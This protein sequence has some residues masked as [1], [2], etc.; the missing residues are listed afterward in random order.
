MSDDAALLGDIQVHNVTLHSF[1]VTVDYKQGIDISGQNELG[2]L[3][4]VFFLQYGQL[5][6]ERCYERSAYLID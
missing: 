2:E 6:L 4:G 3:C 5:S 1:T